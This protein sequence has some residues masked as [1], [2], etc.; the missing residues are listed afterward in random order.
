M[1]G[2]LPS[3]SLYGSSSTTA[4][5]TEPPDPVLDLLSPLLSSPQAGPSTW[6]AKQAG[7]VREK[8]ENAVK[9]N[10]VCPGWVRSR[11]HY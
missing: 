7:D 6:T 9:D 4:L 3:S 1:S 2:D 8:L 10:K 5:P 11:P